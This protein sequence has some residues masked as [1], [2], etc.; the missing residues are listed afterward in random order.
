MA[1]ISDDAWEFGHEESCPA[2]GNIESA[3]LPKL[4]KGLTHIELAKLSHR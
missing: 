2:A 1:A 4:E 3:E